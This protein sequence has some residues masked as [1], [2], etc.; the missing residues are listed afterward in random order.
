VHVVRERPNPDVP[1]GILQGQGEEKGAAGITLANPY[2]GGEGG[3]PGE[4]PRT[5]RSPWARCIL[6]AKGRSRGARKATAC[7]KACRETLLSVLKVMLR[8]HIVGAAG[9]APAER[10]AHSLAPPWE[11]H[12]EL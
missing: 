12:A 1:Q 9:K 10:V 8:G 6:A 7:N 4:Q 3:R 2:L 11:S 5:T